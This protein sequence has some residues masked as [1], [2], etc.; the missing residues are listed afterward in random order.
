MSGKRS[1]K[2]LTRVSSGQILQLM[3]AG[4]AT[5]ADTISWAVYIMATK[6]DVQD[7]LHAEIE[8]MV[9][10]HP[11]FGFPEIDA[12]PFLNKFIKESLRLYAPCKTYPIFRCSHP[13][14]RR[15]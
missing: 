10:H 14:S 5:S 12:L 3:A 15:H 6:I 9:S 7:R 1:P 8:D 13:N 2:I 4:H 11:K